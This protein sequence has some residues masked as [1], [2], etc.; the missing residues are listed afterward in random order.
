MKSI[1]CI[2][3]FFVIHGVA[4]SQNQKFKKTFVN[5]TELGVLLGR[6]KYSYGYMESKVD[7]RLSMTAQTFNGVRLSSRLAV[8]ATVGMDW[9]K[10]A[11]I[12][13]IAAGIRYD[14]TKN[15][16]ARLFAS[17]DAGY[18]FTWLH[19]DSDRYDTKGGLMI[20]PGI[21]LK[22]GKPGNAAFT[23]SMAYKRQAARVEKPLQY[24]QTYRNETRVYN[25][26]VLKIGMIF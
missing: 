26:I 11:L 2:L 6:V 8:G 25:R 17:A 15:G 16:P 13:P 19:Q 22:Y 21:G 9:Y 4:F 14:L 3:L 23:I 18:G 5:H 7:S 24:E 12:N 1:L 10:T 20:N